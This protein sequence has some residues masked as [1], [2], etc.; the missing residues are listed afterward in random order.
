MFYQV[1]S[2]KEI[3]NMLGISSGTLRIWLNERYYEELQEIG[4]SKRQ[5]LLTPKQLNYLMRKID[6]TGEK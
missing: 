3:A 5:K 4:Y 2:K 6:F 1:L